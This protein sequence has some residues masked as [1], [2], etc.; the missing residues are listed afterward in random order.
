M[1]FFVGGLASIVALIAT[2]PVLLV[3]LPFWLVGV[4]QR[5][6]Q[7]GI[8][9]A[10]GKAV[11]WEKLM[12][13]APTIGWK[14]KSNVSARALDLAGNGFSVTTDAD[15][16]RRPLHKPREYDVYVF[17]DSFAFGFGAS[18]RDFFPNLMR[19]PRV[20]AI[21]ANGYNMVQELLLMERYAGEL[22]GRMVVWFVYHGN[23]LVENLTPNMRRYRMPFVREVGAE[24]QKWEIVT[25]HVNPSP[26]D[27]GVNRDYYALLAEVCCDSTLANRAFSA[28]DFLIG[29]AKALCD[30]ASAQLIVVSLPDVLQIDPARRELLAAK[31]PDPDSFDVDRPDAALR[32]ICAEHEVEFRTTRDVLTPRHFIEGDVHWNRTGNQRMAEFLTEIFRRRQGHDA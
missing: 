15:G 20:R 17:G 11:S 19:S 9:R 26:W 4:G 3:A 16:W 2:I 29:R 23:D 32:A 21:G 13:Y 31:A 18:D 30:Q 10:Q 12:E 5:F 14:P 22:A 27:I 8:L 28:C 25:T 24:G 1:R 6:I 7:R